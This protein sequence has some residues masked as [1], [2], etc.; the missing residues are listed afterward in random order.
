MVAFTIPAI[1]KDK[2][3]TGKKV[4]PGVLFTAP[5]GVMRGATS[6]L[7]IRG[8]D[9][10]EASEAKCELGGKPLHA[11]IKSKSKSAPPA[12]LTPEAVGESQVEVELE[13]P[14]DAPAS[15]V[16]ITIVTPVGAT[17]PRALR[18]FA[19]GALTPEKEPN[20]GFPNAQKIHP[21]TTIQGAIQEPNDVDVFRF[22]ASKGQKLSAHVIAAQLGS[23]LDS[24]LT[25]YDAHHHVIAS[26]DD[27]DASPDSSLD[28][29][30]TRD[31]EYYLSVTDANGRGGALYAYL[32]EVRVK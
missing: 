21:A 2:K 6:K 15:D 22:K 7:L 1:A 4:P 32:L 5:L 24:L 11:T 18:T 28:I 30:L 20:G 3:D 14:A 29:A 8:H 31:G 12:P 25:L 9:L 13:I 10:S 23:P 27:T 19:A 26:N 17:P 16:S